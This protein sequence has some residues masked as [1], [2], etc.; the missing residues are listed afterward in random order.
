MLP[1][2]AVVLK[3]NTLDLKYLR[4]GIFGLANMK[5]AQH[6]LACVAWCNNEHTEALD[7]VGE[8]LMRPLDFISGVRMEQ[9]YTVLRYA[10]GSLICHQ[11]FFSCSRILATRRA[12]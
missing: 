12:K 10:H 8:K 5:D 4:Y 7:W 3:I 1:S 9:L 2:L 6:T 11:F